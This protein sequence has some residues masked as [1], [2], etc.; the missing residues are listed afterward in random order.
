MYETYIRPP[1]FELYDLREDPCERNNLAGRQEMAK[2]EARLK[3]AL[4]EWRKETRDPLLDG[5][6]LARLLAEHDALMARVEAARRDGAD[7][8]RITQLR[9]FRAGY[10][11]PARKRE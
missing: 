7:S 4:L 11:I 9:Q 10:H 6:E 5:E 2:M 1:E 8:R 3:K